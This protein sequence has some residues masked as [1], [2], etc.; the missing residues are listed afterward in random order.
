MN[1]GRFWLDRVANHSTL[2]RTLQSILSVLFSFNFFKSPF[3]VEIPVIFTTIF[4]WTQENQ[5]GN[6]GLIIEGA[7]MNNVVYMYG[8]QDSTLTVKGKVNSVFLDSCRKTSVL[9]DSLV[10]SIEFVNC[11]S[12]QMQV[13][14]IFFVCWGILKSLAIFNFNIKKKVFLSSN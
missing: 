11:Q 8:C 2:V 6:H 12:V 1:I 10:S 3:S 5:I 14:L 4:S 7:D 9:V 13:I